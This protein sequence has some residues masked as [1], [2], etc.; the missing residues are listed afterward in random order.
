MLDGGLGR[1]LGEMLGEGVENGEFVERVK[2]GERGGYKV[3]EGWEGEVGT[4]CEYLPAWSVF[5]NP[6]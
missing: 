5:R 6:F 3:E 4:K 2:K 1:W